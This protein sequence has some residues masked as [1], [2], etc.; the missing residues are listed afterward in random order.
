MFG[1]LDHDFVFFISYIC[2]SVFVFF[3]V[4]LFYNIS[5]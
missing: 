1:V 5:L 4:T 2:F 3:L